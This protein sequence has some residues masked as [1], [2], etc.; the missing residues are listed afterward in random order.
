MAGLHESGDGRLQ[1]GQRFTWPPEY[2]IR[3]HGQWNA[4]QALTPQAKPDALSKTP[5]Y[6][7]S[8]RPQ[9]RWE[10]IRSCNT[11]EW[12]EPRACASARRTS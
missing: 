5:R 3:S 1:S 6:S 8:E 10:S 12:A 9:M 4:Q 2:G 11:A 7:S